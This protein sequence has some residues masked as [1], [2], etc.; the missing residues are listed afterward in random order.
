MIDFKV[1]DKV[2]Y[3]QR[4]IGQASSQKIYGLIKGLDETHAKIY[5]DEPVSPLITVT[6]E[7]KRLTHAED[8][9]GQQ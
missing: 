7:L 6:I 5:R 4:R 9:V 2:W 8:T 3:W 1:G